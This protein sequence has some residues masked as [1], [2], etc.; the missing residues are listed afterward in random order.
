MGIVLLEIL[1]PKFPNQPSVAPFARK[2]DI[3][4]IY[5]FVVSNMSNMFELR[6]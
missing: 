3:Q 1:V 6:F 4:S 5:V 2:M